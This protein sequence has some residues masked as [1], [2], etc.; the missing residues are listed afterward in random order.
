MNTQEDKQEKKER[1][2]VMSGRLSYILATFFLVGLV[3][4]APGTF[5]S[6]AGMTAYLLL[7]YIFCSKAML[8][9]FTVLL[10]FFGVYVSNSVSSDTSSNDPSYIVIDEVVG[11]FIAM[12]FITELSVFSCCLA[13]A[14]FRLFDIAKPY[15]V[16][17]CESFPGGWGIMLDDAAAGLLAGVLNL[18][19]LTV[20]M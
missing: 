9:I 12:L 5:G 16:N 2:A 20:F 17:K 8:L 6:A 11:I 18:T 7:N 3:P 19:V 13:F 1:R 4:F 10:F 15:P 14:L